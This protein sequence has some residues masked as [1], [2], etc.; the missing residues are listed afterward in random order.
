LRAIA[1]ILVIIFHMN[2]SWIPGGFIGVD[3]FFV[4]S[5][6]IIT[7]AIYP[8]IL[9]KQFS[10][11][12]FYVKRIKRI[13][14]LFY[15]VSLTSLVLSYLLYTPND[16]ASFADSWRYASSF[17]ANI[18]F[19]RLSGYFAPTSETL[20]LLHTWSLSIEEQF[21]FVWPLVLLISARFLG[22]KLFAVVM[23]ITV[24]VLLAYS[25]FISVTS[26]GAGYYLIQSRGFELLIGAL[27]S[28]LF[29]YKR[30]GEVSLPKPAYQLSGIIG[31]S[32][33]FALA[34]FLD[35]DSVFPGVN[36]LWVAL[37]S[38]MI[39]LSGESKATWVSS[40]LS[41]KPVVLVGRLSYSLYLWHWPV[42]AF[43]R[44]YNDTFT[45]LD[46][47]ICG[48]ITV[49]LSIASWQLIEN[50][51]RHLNLKKRWVYLFYFVLPVTISIIAAKNIA[52]NDGYPERFTDKAL[53]L[54]Q[55]SSYTY[56]EEKYLQPLKDKSEPFEPY[57][58]GDESKPINT[59]IWGDSHAG[60][61]RSFVDEVGNEFG[62]SSLIA[63]SAGCPPLLG[64]DLI[65]HGEP[66]APCTNRNNRFK[67]AI[68]KTK[69]AVVFLAA[70]W[71]M[72]TETTRANGER[73]SRVYLGDS[74]D[75]SESINNSRRAF[76]LGLQNT[77]EFLLE[78]EIVPVLFEQA[79]S[80]SFKP[81]NCLMKNLAYSW[82]VSSSCDLP[83]GDMESRQEYSNQVVRDIASK[84]PEVL[85]IPTVSLMCDGEECK[86]NDNGVPFYHDNNHLNSQGARILARKWLETNTYQ[87]EILE[88]ELGGRGE[89]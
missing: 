40:V 63:G 32:S 13:L 52:S 4:I 58:I 75:Y 15:V 27:L 61:F 69:P 77:V 72:Y 12:E 42:L 55:I 38:A 59:I 80:Y 29:F 56:D 83:I 46:A 30:K 16:F 7:S 87:A 70:R 33:L 19:E 78:N 48:L 88:D 24:V 2:G 18:Y 1:V 81:S 49:V 23:A 50:P 3:V 67:E 71:A 89:K 6:Y 39:I 44:Y 34:F 25:E 37:A 76:N 21:Y 51:L 35:K 8:Q 66:E 62:F 11:N 43:Y 14:P 79:P 20:P 10:F 64:S 22:N 86:S 60:H 26:P 47:L 85:L 9:A 54:Y 31:F 73:G 53:R 84:Y 57:I 68:E 82:K 36:A 74:S 65:K 5:G 41:Q 17:I 45:A 28:I